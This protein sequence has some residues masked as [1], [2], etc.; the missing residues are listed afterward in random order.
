MYVCLCK[1]ITDKQIIDAV[2]NGMQ[3]FDEVQDNLGVATNCGACREY[4]QELVSEHLA[5]QLSF[6]A[7]S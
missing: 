2:D 6:P 4:A 7:N 1:A 3:N 5:D